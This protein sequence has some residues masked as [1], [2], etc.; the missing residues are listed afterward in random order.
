MVVFLVWQ[1]FLV[2]FSFCFFCPLLVVAGH[3][4]LAACE[5]V[6]HNSQTPVTSLY[7][8]CCV[9]LHRPCSV[10]GCNAGH[11]TAQILHPVYVHTFHLDSPTCATFSGGKSLLLE[12]ALSVLL[13]DVPRTWVLFSTVHAVFPVIH[14]DLSLYFGPNSLLY[15]FR[16]FQVEPEQIEACLYLRQR[17]GKRRKIH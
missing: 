13:W 7:Q 17:K 15:L 5:R 14:Q 12:K 10:C 6:I 9:H 16:R 3:Q 8:V 11:W 2:F 4:V 1:V